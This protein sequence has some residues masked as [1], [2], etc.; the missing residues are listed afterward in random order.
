MHELREV[1]KKW[2][3]CDFAHMIDFTRKIL[4][5]NIAALFSSRITMKTEDVITFAGFAN[6]IGCLLFRRQQTLNPLSIAGHIFSKSFDGDFYS[7]GNSK[8]LTNDV[9]VTECINRD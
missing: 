1:K 5:T 4:K 2:W 3:S 8:A 6:F 9:Y 7:I